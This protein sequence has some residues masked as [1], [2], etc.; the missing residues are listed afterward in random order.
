MDPLLQKYIFVKACLD[1]GELYRLLWQKNFCHTKNPMYNL[2]KAQAHR[3]I[4][5]KENGY[6]PSGELK[7]LQNILARGSC[8][9]ENSHFVIY[10]ARHSGKHALIVS[11]L[12]S[13]ERPLVGISS[14]EMFDG[15]VVNAGKLSRAMRHASLVVFK[16]QLKIVEGEVVSITPDRIHLKTKDMESTF[17]I[18]AK[19]RSELQKERVCIGD[20]IKI[21][22]ES[23]FVNRVGRSANL[24]SSSDQSIYPIV[25][26]PEGECIKLEAVTTKLSLDE[27]DIL[28]YKENGEEL[29]YTD[30][31]VSENVRSEVGKRVSK[32][33]KEAKATFLRGCLV[34][35]DSQTLSKDAFMSVMS[36]ANRPLSP[37]II[38]VV[39]GEP[40]FKSCGELRFFID[41]LDSKS[42][43]LV[44]QSVA[45]SSNAFLEEEAADILQALALKTNISVAISV[46]RSSIQSNR[47]S[48]ES[49]SRIT[50]LFDFH[51]E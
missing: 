32:W 31:C 27:L 14:N 18:G 48:I 30:L 13:E 5:G 4:H 25:P 21:Y 35:D 8:A 36:M 40:A 39:D 43:K 20:V 45:N 46:L 47:V 2:C 1:C 34:I 19:M 44:L 16:E 38:F 24:Q 50:S 41:R 6:V 23:G 9:A 11:A 29:L 26:L 42:T 12:K 33:V 51:L 10:G 7:V 28:N 3:H 49:V 17:E 37:S 22:K 15:G